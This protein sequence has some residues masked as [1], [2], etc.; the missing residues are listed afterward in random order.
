M[1][2]KSKEIYKLYD[3]GE[4]ANGAVLNILLSCIKNEKSNK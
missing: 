3:M 2:L 4:S 1:E